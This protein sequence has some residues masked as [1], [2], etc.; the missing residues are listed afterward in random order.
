MA[1]VIRGSTAEFLSS[2]QFLAVVDES[3]ACQPPQGTGWS[4][5]LVP[6]LLSRGSRGTKG[7][8]RS[9]GSS[10]VALGSKP[11]PRLPAPS[12]YSQQA[13][14]RGFH[15]GSLCTPFLKVRGRY[16]PHP[17]PGLPASLRTGSALANPSLTV[18]KEHSAT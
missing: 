10:Q 15:P 3:I 4:Q 8:G 9:W 5:R 11:A 2:S 12:P 17:S 13:P 18:S 7:T 1:Q 14:T 16:S 6:F